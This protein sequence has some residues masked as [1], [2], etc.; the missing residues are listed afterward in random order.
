MKT[1]I[2]IVLL[3]SLV[4]IGLIFYIS[5]DLTIRSFREVILPQDTQQEG[6]VA[7]RSIA[8]CPS[9]LDCFKQAEETTGLCYKNGQMSLP[10]PV[11]REP[12]IW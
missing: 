8:D 9:G 1:I 4:A 5:P 3:G 11:D 7:C 6:V 2:L 12:S 10:T